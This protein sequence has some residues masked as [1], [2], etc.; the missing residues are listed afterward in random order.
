MGL[1][2]G[3]PPQSSPLSQRLPA[4]HP[5]P[6]APSL[7]YEAARN[8][9]PPDPTPR[10]APNS[11]RGSESTS[12]R[13]TVSEPGCPAALPRRARVHARS[14]RPGL[15]PPPAPAGHVPRA[16]GGRDPR[17]DTRKT[18]SKT[19]AAATRDTS[20]P[21]RGGPRKGGKPS[22]RRG[23]RGGGGARKAQVG[24]AGT[25]GRPGGVLRAL[26]TGGPA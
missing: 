17:P 8:L 20:A 9:P 7:G 26:R 18:P 19:L 21:G 15:R 12:R 23:P 24:C 25:G 4:S 2:S 6:S 16:K 5:A 13:H 11:S 14:G 1:C 3:S 10:I 22:A